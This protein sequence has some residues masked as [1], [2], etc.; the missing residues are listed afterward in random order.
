MKTRAKSPRAKEAK[1]PALLLWA[2]LQISATA[3]PNAASTASA[4]LAVASGQGAC[5]GCATASGEE[6]EYGLGEPDSGKNSSAASEQSS[7]LRP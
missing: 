3:M 6:G 1:E 4:R 7:P 5:G 2:L